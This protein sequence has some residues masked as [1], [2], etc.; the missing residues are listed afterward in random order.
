MSSKAL[1]VHV[2]H[3]YILI[4]LTSS[5]FRI[6]SLSLWTI[7]H[8]DY[9]CHDPSICSVYLSSLMVFDESRYSFDEM[10]AELLTFNSTSSFVLVSPFFFPLP[11]NSMCCTIRAVA[12]SYTVWPSYYHCQWS[13]TWACQYD[14]WPLPWLHMKS[15]ITHPSPLFLFKILNPVKRSHSNFFMK[16]DILAFRP[17]LILGIED[18]VLSC[19]NIWT[20]NVP[21]YFDW[22]ARMLIGCPVIIYGMVLHFD[23]P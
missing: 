12:D 17:V 14:T 11:K 13:Y 20:E 10:Q 23:V 9:R 8:K 15:R 1:A 3:I 4:V 5:F 19:L 7:N 22:D 21:R 18:V 6:I 16:Q 2:I